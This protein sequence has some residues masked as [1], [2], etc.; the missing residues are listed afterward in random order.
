MIKNHK[1]VMIIDD[2]IFLCFPFWPHVLLVL[3]IA[4]LE[5]GSHELDR[6]GLI[7]V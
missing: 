6:P 3:C 2:E 1:I 7:L 5:Y 4:L